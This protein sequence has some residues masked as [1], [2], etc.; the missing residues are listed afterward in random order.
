MLLYEVGVCALHA[1][2][3]F[4]SPVSRILSAH[5]L[6]L[7]LTRSSDLGSHGRL[8][9]TLPTT[10]RTCLAFL[11]RAGFIA[12][13]PRR[14]ALSC[15]YARYNRP[16]R[17]WFI[18]VPSLVLGQRAKPC[19]CSA[20]TCPVSSRN[21]TVDTYRIARV[22]RYHTPWREISDPIFSKTYLNPFST[23]GPFWRQST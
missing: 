22:I 3:R 21:R 6:C 7:P 18:E 1:G 8:F 13:F 16:S 20:R 2:C 12:V 23:S 15:A 11:S 14:L 19:V 5:F 17:Q 10:A 4:F 9:S